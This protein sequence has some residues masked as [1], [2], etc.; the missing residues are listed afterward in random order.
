MSQRFQIQTESRFS[1]HNRPGRYFTPLQ[2]EDLRFTQ[3]TCSN[4]NFRHFMLSLKSQHL[5]LC[6]GVGTCEASLAPAHG[7]W[8]HSLEWPSCCCLWGGDSRRGSSELSSGLLGA[9]GSS[10][11]SAHSLFIPQ[12]QRLLKETPGLGSALSLSPGGFFDS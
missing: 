11:L 4:Q 12:A 2:K 3:R 5:P 7:R 6:C 8:S 10:P 9:G 1:T